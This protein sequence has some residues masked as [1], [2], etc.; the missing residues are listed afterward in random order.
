MAGKGTKN[1]QQNT[2]GEVYPIAA[3]H[4]RGV[5]SL[6]QHALLPMLSEQQQQR[7]AAID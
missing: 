7:I 6:L 2:Q 4:G 1:N 3:V 5:L